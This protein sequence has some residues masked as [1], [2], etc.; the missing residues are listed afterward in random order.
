MRRPPMT[1]DRDTEFVAKPRRVPLVMFDM[2]LSGILARNMR[3]VA[4]RT[5]RWLVTKGPGGAAAVMGKY[6]RR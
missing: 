2:H 5:S 3:D 1:E 6:A 4:L